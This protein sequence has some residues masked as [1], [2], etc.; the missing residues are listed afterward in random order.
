MTDSQK[1]LVI[2]FLGPIGSGKSYFAKQLSEK[3]QIVRFNSDAIRQAMGDEWSEEAVRK[4]AGA[5]DYV[6]EQVLRN[7]QSVIYDTA[8]FN[9]LDARQALRAIAE[10]THAEVVLVWVES[11]RD[12]VVDRVT[13]REPSSEHLRFTNE[14]AEQILERHDRAFVP[15]QDDEMCIKIDGTES[16]NEQYQSFQ[17]QLKQLGL[18]FE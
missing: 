17:E 1:P 12:V 4:V 16:F 2:T 15:P 18:S 11:P 13:S 10:K 8:R 7:H 3:L 9:K 14:E 5:L 6:V